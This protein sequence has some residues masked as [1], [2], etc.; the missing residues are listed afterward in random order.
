MQ[1]KEGI[2]PLLCEICI[3]VLVRQ[4]FLRPRGKALRY[5]SRQKPCGPSNTVGAFLTVWE[6]DAYPSTVKG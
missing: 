2:P 5:E 6:R 1:K 3:S 4:K